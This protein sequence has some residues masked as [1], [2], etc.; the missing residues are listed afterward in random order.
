MCV[1]VCVCVCAYYR[2]KNYQHRRKQKTCIS[3][4]YLTT[5]LVYKATIPQRELHLKTLSFLHIEKQKL[6]ISTTI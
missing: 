1:C 6:L 5:T 2:E 4:K 3:F